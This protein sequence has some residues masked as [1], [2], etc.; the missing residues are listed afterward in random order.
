MKPEL[1]KLLLAERKS[2]R[3]LAELRAVR[4]KLQQQVKPDA[5]MIKVVDDEISKLL[6]S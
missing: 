6:P 2:K 4:L 3:E 5:A 1:E